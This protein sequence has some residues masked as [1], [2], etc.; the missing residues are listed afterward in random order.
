MPV[1]ISE[2][3]VLRVFQAMRGG[4][5]FASI[6]ARLGV[7][8]RSVAAVALG[9]SHAGVLPDHP[10]RKACVRAERQRLSAYDREREVR[11]SRKWKKQM[12]WAVWD[13]ILGCSVRTA[14]A[15][16]CVGVSALYRELIRR[17]TARRPVGK[18]SPRNRGG[19]SA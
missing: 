9:R 15:R 6:A 13:Y 4:E 7:A 2:S 16:N 18:R 8:D 17:G 3:D 1:K 19:A 12:Q 5:T 14:A 10:D 11:A